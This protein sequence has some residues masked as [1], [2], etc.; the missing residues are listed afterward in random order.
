[1]FKM[2]LPDLTYRESSILNSLVKSFV[3]T[4][5]PIGSKYLAKTVRQNVSPATIRKVF[6]CLEK[7]GLVT[8]PHTSA[9]RIPTDLGY[10]FYV[11]DLMKVERL[12]PVEKNRI[13]HDLKELFREDVDTIL[14]KACDVLSEISHQLGVVLSPKFYQGVFEKLEL[15]QLS[16]N[17]LLVVITVSSGII[18]TILMG[19]R[20]KIQNYKIEETE[21]ILNE[22]L[23]GLT[24]REIRDSI[25]KRMNDIGYGDSNL[26]NQFTEKADEIFIIDNDNVHF[27]GASN[28]LAQPEFTNTERLA[29][30]LQLIDNQNVLVHIIKNS[31]KKDEGISIT[32]GREHKQELV[33]NCSLISTTYKIGDITGTLAV[34]GP[35]R[36][37]YEKITAVVDYIGKGISN[38][39]S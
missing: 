14:E 6:M 11:N 34:I 10:R 5:M 24:L 32:I 2:E 4:A 7:K 30:I 37:R 27:K 17:K 13:D 26:I 22:R 38:L 29:K 9:G 33:N 28:I 31:T 39:F 20:F 23:S 16:E 1:M 19:I 8:Q 21:N 12:S 18:R 25:K 3:K 15:V 36:M 35:T